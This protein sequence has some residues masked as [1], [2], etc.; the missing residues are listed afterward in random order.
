MSDNS[1]RKE[2]TLAVDV[3]DKVGIESG[4]DSAFATPDISPDGSMFMNG[5]GSTILKL[6]NLTGAPLIDGDGS[7]RVGSGII[8]SD[9]E[10]SQIV[11][12]RKTTSPNSKVTP[13][14]RKASTNKGKFSTTSVK[15]K[16][17]VPGTQFHL[18]WVVILVCR[19]LST[20]FI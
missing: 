10:G 19:S 15:T 9:D 7:G 18:F 20:F 11:K 2:E 5:E 13:Q 17:I 4:P 16:F 3:T 8:G 12:R 6:D 1:V 14:S